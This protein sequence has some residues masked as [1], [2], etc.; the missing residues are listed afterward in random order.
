MKLNG[1]YQQAG[2]GLKILQLVA[3]TFVS[4]MFFTLISLLITGN[5]LS[6]INAL[7]TAQLFQ[8]MGIFFFPPLMLAVMWSVNPLKR[9][10]IDH[11]PDLRSAFFAIVIMVAAIPGINLLSELNHA[12]SFPD[13]LSFIE[14]YLIAMEDRAEDLTNRILAGSSIS[15]LLI[16]IGLIGVIPA[17]GEELFFRGTIQRLLQDKMKMHAAVWITAFIFSSIHFQF[18]GF[19]PRLLMGAF[20]GYLYAWTNNLWV[21]IIAHFTNNTIAVVF[22]FLKNAG[23]TTVDLENIGSS[24]TY[25]I[26]MI[27]I[28]IVAVLIFSFRPKSSKPS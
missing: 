28:V 22:Y 10:K 26:G 3:F 16:N 27:S 21:P 15:D 12:I 18:Y 5:D 11:I 7:K 20:L 4:A 6:G 25:L 8:S 9:L 2:T 13:A 19:I 14:K 24:E 23:H 1:L 17:V